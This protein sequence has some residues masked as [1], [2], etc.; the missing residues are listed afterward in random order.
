MLF[1]A[2]KRYRAAA[3]CAFCLLGAHTAAGMQSSP[4]SPAAL[5]VP[6][7]GVASDRQLVSQ[8]DIIVL[9]Q[10]P[11]ASS[12][13]PTGRREGGRTVV[14]YVQ[15]IKVSQTWK[16]SA[17]AGVRLLTSGVEPLPDAADPL[18]KRY[19][20]PL[21]GGEYVCF[22]KK[23]PGADYYTLTGL[24]QGLYPVFEGRTNALLANGGFASFDQLPVDK[25]KAKVKSLAPSS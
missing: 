15:Q 14:H 8:S 25:L 22:L 10:I 19:T 24:W 17:R 7:A 23:V 12:S 11:E 20:G 6:Q 1:P 16:G 18:N 9:G 5:P 2:L 4:A 3:C 21:A 13:Y